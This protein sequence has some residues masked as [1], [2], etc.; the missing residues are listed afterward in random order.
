MKIRTLLVAALMVG[1]YGQSQAQSSST[2]CSS[3][4]SSYAFLLSI[5]DIADA[6]E[7]KLEHPACYGNGSADTAQGIN[8]TA[9]LQTQA[10]SRA[11]GARFGLNSQGGPIASSGNTG[12]AAGGVAQ[13]WNVWGSLEQSDTDVSY[14]VVA[15]K[16]KGNSDVQNTIL[17]ADYSLNPAMVVG[18]SLA[19]DRGDSWSRNVTGGGNKIKSDTDGYLVSPYFGYQINKEFAFDAS[20]GFGNGDFSNNT[21]TADI[22]RWFAGANLSYNRWV[23]NL[24]FSGKISYLHGEEDFSDL[25]QRATGAR[26]LNSGGENK[27]DQIGLGAQISYWMNGVMPFAGLAYTSNVHRVSA[28]GDDPIGRDS[29]VATLGVNFISVANKVTGGI[30]YDQEFTRKNSDNQVISANINFRF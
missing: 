5:G 13:R 4:Y 11:I 2:D 3:T 20:V 14:K 25:K 12:L 27:V 19:F 15:N 22:D 6:E 30:R 18:L 7:E 9:G 1:M 23:N 28:G 21:S 24:Q 16:I 8:T 29:F 10:I 26:V 17:G